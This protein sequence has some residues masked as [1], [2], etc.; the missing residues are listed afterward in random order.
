MRPP[1]RDDEPIVI[2]FT[3]Q[4]QRLGKTLLTLERTRRALKKCTGAYVVTVCEKSNSL[5]VWFAFGKVR[6]IEPSSELLERAMPMA[7]ALNVSVVTTEN[8]DDGE[9]VP[10]PIVKD[11]DIPF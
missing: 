6:P 1:I 7:R 5:G 8:K 9:N 10:V 3:K 11:A 4:T 2:A